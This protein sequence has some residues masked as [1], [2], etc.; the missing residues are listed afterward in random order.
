MKC[1]H[2]DAEHALEGVDPLSLEVFHAFKRT[3]RLN[4]QLLGRSAM[5]EGGHPAQAGCLWALAHSDGITQRQLAER[6]YLAPATVTTM[7]QRM[8]REGTVERWTDPDDQRLTRIRLTEAGRE[9]AHRHGATQVEFINRV[10]G[11]L[12]ESD[13]RDL[14]R[15]LDRLSDNAAKELER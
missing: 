15:I 11:G 6:L 5:A 12:P 2:P 9:L 3:M 13:R 1:N 10:I 8:E 14:I 7:L 4:R